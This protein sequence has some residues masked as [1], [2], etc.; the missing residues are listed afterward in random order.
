MLS[1]PMLTNPSA[2]AYSQ[3]AAPGRAKHAYVVVDLTAELVLVDEGIDSHRAEEVTDPLADAA[4]G[5]LLAQG[6]RRCEG[7]PVGAAEHAAEHVYGD[8]ERVALV[9]PLFAT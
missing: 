7:P 2:R 3:L 9:A 6:E 5:D 1:R 4:R 8:G